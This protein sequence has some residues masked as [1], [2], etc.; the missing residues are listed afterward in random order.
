MPLWINEL[1]SKDIMGH[2]Q[3]PYRYLCLGLRRQKP[4]KPRW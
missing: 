2:M 1:S 4:K 3:K